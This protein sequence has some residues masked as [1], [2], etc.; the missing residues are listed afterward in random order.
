MDSTNTHWLDTE[1]GEFSSDETKRKSYR[2]QLALLDQY[3]RVRAN[4]ASTWGTQRGRSVLT[5][6]IIDDRARHNHKVQGFPVH[7]LLVLNALLDIHDNRFP[8]HKPK[9]EMWDEAQ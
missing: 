7:I 2:Y 3:P 4:I 9:A 1:P 6:L 8:Q 5:G